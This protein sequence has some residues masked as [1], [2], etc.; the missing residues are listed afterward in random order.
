LKFKVSPAV[1]IP[2]P[3]TE[4]LVEWI[5]SDWKNSE[6]DIRILDIGTGS[7]CIAIT[8]KSL[9]GKKSTVVAIDIS[10]E[11]LLI[12]KENAKQLKQEVEFREHDFLE[13]GFR[14]LGRFDLIVSNPPYVDRNGPATILERLRFEPTMALFPKGP[15]VNIFYKKIASE[16]HEIVEKEG[17][18]YTELNE[19]NA[20]EIEEVFF[21]VGWNWSEIRNDLQGLPRMLKASK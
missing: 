1:L 17:A 12:A 21:G 5:Y 3:E 7:G 16:G 11:A 6:T 13:E 20:G 14:G 19:F 8:L 15:D 2:R 18:C 9:L 4:E 10:A